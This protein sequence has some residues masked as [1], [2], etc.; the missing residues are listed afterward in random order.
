[1]VLFCDQ[2]EVLP[3]HVVFQPALYSAEPASE[4]GAP[5]FAPEPPAKA[6]GNGKDSLLST[7]IQQHIRAIYGSSGNNQRKAARLLG[8]SRSRLARHL[9]AM[10]LQCPPS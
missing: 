5:V 1:V 9:R 10:D 7:A 4:N 8:I 6:L 2:D 3:E